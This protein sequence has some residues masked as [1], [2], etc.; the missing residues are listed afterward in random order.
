VKLSEIVNQPKNSVVTVS[1]TMF[2]FKN[3]VFGPLNICVCVLYGFRK[4][5]ACFAVRH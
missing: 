1:S 2:I 4:D 3:Y 5:G